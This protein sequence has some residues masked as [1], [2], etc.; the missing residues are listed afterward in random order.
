MGGLLSLKNHSYWKHGN[1][2][3]HT[4]V[5]ALL[6]C[7]H[8]FL[9]PPYSSSDFATTKGAITKT[10]YLK[11]TENQVKEAIRCYMVLPGVMRADLARVS[12]AMAG[13]KGPFTFETRTRSDESIGDGAVVCFNAVR[14]WLFNAGF[15]SLRWMAQNAMLLDANTA[16]NILGNGVIIPVA[17]IAQMGVGYIFNFHV[18]NHPEVCHWG[19]SLG[20]GLA[21]GSNTTPGAAARDNGVLVSETVHFVA[22]DGV[23]GEFL[24]SESAQVCKLKYQHGNVAEAIVIRSL[25]PFLI[26]N[27]F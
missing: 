7:Q 24:L 8:A 23:C 20:G 4:A 1:A 18:V 21:A 5:R 2:A 10:L 22:G 9:K 15:V 16:N 12:R 11:K 17:N 26:P 25:A 19:V 14:T 3:Q 27:R 13:A 6:L